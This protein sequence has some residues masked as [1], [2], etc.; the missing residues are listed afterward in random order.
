MAKF[1]R[2][3]REGSPDNSIYYS[4]HDKESVVDRAYSDLGAAKMLIVRQVDYA[5]PNAIVTPVGLDAEESNQIAQRNAPLLDT[6]EAI[7]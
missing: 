1:F 3:Y 5:P 6:V 7:E 2:V 4:G